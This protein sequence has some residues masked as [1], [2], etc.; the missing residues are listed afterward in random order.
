[1]QYHFIAIDFH[2]SAKYF[3]SKKHASNVSMQAMQSHI[4]TCKTCKHVST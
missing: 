1:M 3:S 4:E 2:A